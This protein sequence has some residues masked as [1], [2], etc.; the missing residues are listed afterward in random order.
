MEIVILNPIQSP[1]AIQFS[2]NF[3]L[4]NQQKS[5]TY[6]VGLLYTTWGSPNLSLEVSDA[7]R[8]FRFFQPKNKTHVDQLGMLFTA[9]AVFHQ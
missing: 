4:N 5:C 9:V 8:S 6:A 2:G 1:F 7:S 3:S